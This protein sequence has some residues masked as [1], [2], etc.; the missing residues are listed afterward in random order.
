MSQRRKVVIGI[1]GRGSQ[2]SEV[3]LQENWRAAIEQGLPQGVILPA[4]MPVMAYYADIYFEQPEAQVEQFSV[5]TNT[6]NT[7]ADGTRHTVATWL[8]IQDWHDYRS[9]QD[10]REALQKRLTD[11]LYRYRGYDIFLIAHS[12]GTLIAY[13]V[14][15]Q[16][17]YSIHTFVTI[18]SALKVS[19]PL[20]QRPKPN[21]VRRWYNLQGLIDPIVGSTPLEGA[22]NHQLLTVRHDAVD[23][24]SCDKLGDL[25]AAFLPAPP[26]VRTG[27]PRPANHSAMAVYASYPSSHASPVYYPLPKLYYYVC[28]T[29]KCR[30]PQQSYPYQPGGRNCP[31]CQQ[32]MTCMSN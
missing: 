28:T 2:A 27:V 21:G 20:T 9:D 11:V 4:G 5:V 26:P 7:I 19:A 16:G 12:M 3:Q 22:E 6:T 25:L 30:F 15:R 18:G 32:E 24:L 10:V 14:L 8:P 29:P 23:Y 13:D 17:I 31:G 1:H